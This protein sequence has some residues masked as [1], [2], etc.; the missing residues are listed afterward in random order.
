MYEQTFRTGNKK[1]T[2]YC[3]IEYNDSINKIKFTEPVRSLLMEKNVWIKPDF[4]STKTVSNPG[5]FTMVH[6]KI[7]HKQEYISYL[8]KILLDTEDEDIEQVCQQSTQL[9]DNHKDQPKTA[10]PKF[11][12][13]S[14]MRKWGNIQVEVLSVYCSK[15]DVRSV[16]HLLAVTSSK[17]LISK[18]TFV[19]TGPYVLS[20]RYVCRFE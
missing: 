12:L 1:V 11:H 10:T 16:K 20:A 9:E 2:M 15:E 17:G 8:R 5:F 18:G 7:T 19:P 14:S 3:N 6:P 4:Y 13:E